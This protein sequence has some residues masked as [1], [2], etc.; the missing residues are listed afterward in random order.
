MA[1]IDQQRNHQDESPK[2]KKPHVEKSLEEDAIFEEFYSDVK[3][4]VCIKAIQKWN[5]YSLCTLKISNCN[6]TGPYTPSQKLFVRLS[7]TS[8][9]IG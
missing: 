6:A 4:L 9:S 2:P 8:M 5:D 3:L 7:V 1:D